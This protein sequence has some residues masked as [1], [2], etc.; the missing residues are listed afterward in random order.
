M[1]K[2]DVMVRAIPVS[3]L[4][5]EFLISEGDRLMGV[6]NYAWVDGDGWIEIKRDSFKVNSSGYSSEKIKLI[7]QG[8][9][10]ALATRRGDIFCN[11]YEVEYN[12]RKIVMR[13]TSSLKREFILLEGDHQVGCI[14]PENSSS[15]RTSAKFDRLFPTVFQAFLIGLAL[16]S[17]A[18]SS[19]Y[20]VV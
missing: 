6:A 7:E 3:K 17:W 19:Y 13:S 9:E 2:D 15:N 14:E 18:Y 12:G 5:W 4:S 16:N 11:E 8:N 20:D 10:I 1:A